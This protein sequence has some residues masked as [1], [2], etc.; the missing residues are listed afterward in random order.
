[1]GDPDR[2]VRNVATDE[3]ITVYLRGLLTAFLAKREVT[4]EWVTWFR[5]RC[6]LSRTWA[7]FDGDTQCGS[8]RSFPST[9]RLPGGG[10]VPVSCLTQVTVLPTH[11][12]RG[13][14]SRLDARP[15]RRRRRGR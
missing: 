13:H 7:A 10:S 4:E 5:E 11:T 9:V 3:E 8:T 1:M 6:D 15:A 12:R 14:L 2:T